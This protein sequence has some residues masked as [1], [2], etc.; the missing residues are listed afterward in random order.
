MF[1]YWAKPKDCLE[2]S[3]WLND[4]LSR[5]VRRHPD[6]LAGL[7][8]LPMQSV[9]LA[10]EELRRCVEELGLCGVQIGSHV[11]QLQLDDESFDPLWAAAQELGAAIMV[12]PWDMVGREKMPQYWMPWLV[13]MP[14]TTTMAMCSMI[15]GGVFQRFPRLRVCFAHGGGQFAFTI[16]RIEHGWRVRPDLCQTKCTESPSSFIGR[17]WV[18][19]I[20]HDDDALDL[21]VR[22]MG[23]DKV[24]LGSDQPFPLGEHVPGTLVEQSKYLTDHQKRKILFQNTV[25]WLGLTKQSHPDLFSQQEEEE[26]Q[27]QQNQ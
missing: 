12:H 4:D 19:S 11:N 21:L 9:E 3:Q 5:T 2:M 24:C 23:S 25:D 16:G 18:D 10:V 14:A 15:M 7:G 8:T 1:N 17:F 6:R 26:N 13:S 27:A 20:V 22:R